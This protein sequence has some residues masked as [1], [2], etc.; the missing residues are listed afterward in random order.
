[1]TFP[2]R[3]GWAYMVCVESACSLSITGT[4]S[5]DYYTTSNIY[6]LSDHYSIPL[7]A[8]DF[9][10]ISNPNAFSLNVYELVGSGSLSGGAIVQE[11]AFTNI[12]G[13]ETAS[14]PYSQAMNYQIASNKV[15]G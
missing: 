8:G 4:I 9:V 5:Y 11:V 13:A 14:L 12:Y 2:I 10:A 3:V 6:Q 1:M 7:K 15:F